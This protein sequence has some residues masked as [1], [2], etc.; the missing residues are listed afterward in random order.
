MYICPVCQRTYPDDAPAWCPEDGS[1][2]YATGGQHLPA[3]LQPGDVVVE[4]YEILAEIPQR[5]GAGR[6]FKAKQLQLERIVELRLLPHNTVHPT[7]HARFQREVTTWSKLRSDDLVRLYDSGFTPQGA[8]YMALEY[9]EGGSV[10]DRLE[11]GGALAPDLVHT[12]ARQALSALTV[13]HAQGVLHRD[14]SP[15][16]LLLDPHDRCRL[17]GFGLAKFVGLDGGDDPTAITMGVELIGNPAYL[18]PECITQGVFDERTDLYALG[19]CLY[20]LLMGARP[21]PGE[22]LAEILG[23]HIHSRPRPLARWVPSRLKAVIERLIAFEPS[24]RYASA[25]EALDA[26]RVDDLTPPP[27]P[28]YTGDAGALRLRFALTLG[29]MILASA[30]ISAALLYLW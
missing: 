18:A 10:G 3:R 25:A 6:T 13:A 17:T 7:A 27:F 4:K 5:G 12:I 11:R 30:L 2:L 29:G 20:E 8:P 26:L 9:V 23:A 19:I 24:R 21:F 22:N 28:A 14:I 15:H 16:A 1:L